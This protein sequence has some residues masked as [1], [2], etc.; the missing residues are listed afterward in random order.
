MCTNVTIKVDATTMEP[1]IHVRTGAGLVVAGA[2]R[3]KI[4]KRRGERLLL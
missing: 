1:E 2:I 4:V 3:Q